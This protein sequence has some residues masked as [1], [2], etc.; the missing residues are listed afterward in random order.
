VQPL[1]STQSTCADF[2]LRPPPLSPLLLPPK[3]VDRSNTDFPSS[4]QA[5]WIDEHNEP[6]E[7]LINIRN[8]YSTILAG[9]FYR[10]VLDEGHK[11]KNA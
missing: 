10:V 8:K 2:S 3:V 5:L 1:T 4:A 9:Y 7:A 11:V 6:A